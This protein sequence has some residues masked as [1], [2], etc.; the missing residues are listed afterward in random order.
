M[1]LLSTNEGIQLLSSWS[2][3]SLIAVKSFI[4]TTNAMR[5]NHV[6]YEACSFHSPL[7][8]VNHRKRLGPTLI[9]PP[10]LA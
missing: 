7:S 5:E 6:R 8:L 3:P 4:A 2:M 1:P 10:L 9:S